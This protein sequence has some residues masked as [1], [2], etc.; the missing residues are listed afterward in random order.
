MLQLQAIDCMSV[1]LQYH[2]EILL[3]SFEMPIY[4]RE[5]HIRMVDTMRRSALASIEFDKYACRIRMVSYGNV[6]V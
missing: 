4:I 5:G 3:S 1:Y 2:F 6:I